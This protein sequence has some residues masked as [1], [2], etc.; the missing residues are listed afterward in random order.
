VFRA[1]IWIVPIAW[2]SGHFR[3]SL[4][5]AQHP[6]R[7]YRAALAG[8]GT[9]IVLTLLLVPPLRSLGAG[10]A[11]LGGTIANAAAAHVLARGVVPHVALRGTMAPSATA[12]LVCLLLGA[13]LTPV[14]GE[15][16]S[17]L[18][19][20]A[21]LGAAALVV[22]RHSARRFLHMLSGSSAHAST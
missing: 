10:L 9:T 13:I 11:L 20:V 17:T 2:M 22:E 18:A 15:I 8:A 4:I 21:A 19:A 7:D 1:A 16:V 3:Y 5:A 12:C 14:A 6:R